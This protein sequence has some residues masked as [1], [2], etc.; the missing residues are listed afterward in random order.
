MIIKN[1]QALKQL[2]VSDSGKI[3]VE[4]LEDQIEDISNISKIK[5]YDELLGRQEAV[6]LL[7]ELFSFLKKSRE[8][9]PIINRTDY[10]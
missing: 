6:K 10:K 9:T 1:E 4:F 5:S 3:L 8:K 2:A 7:K